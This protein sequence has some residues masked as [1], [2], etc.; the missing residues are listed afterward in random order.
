MATQ[1]MLVSEQ[2]AAIAGLD[3]SAYTG[4]V[5]GSAAVYMLTARER[6]QPDTLAFRFEPGDRFGLRVASNEAVYVWT[7]AGT[8][9]IVYDSTE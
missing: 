6:P 1:S 2:P 3:T 8:S 9:A 5:V 4:Q 7:S